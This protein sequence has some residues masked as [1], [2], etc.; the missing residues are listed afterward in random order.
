[1]IDYVKTICDCGGEVY[2]VGGAIRNHLYNNFHKTSIKTK[3][4]DLLVRLIDQENLVNILKKIGNVKEVGQAFGIII[5]VPFGSKEN[6]EIAIPRTE[7][8]TGS[9]YRDF[10]VTVDP[11]ISIKEDFSRRDATIN[12]IAMRIYSLDD[13]CILQ[14]TD[15]VIDKSNFI[16]PFYGIDDV[17]NKIWKCVGDPKKR[18]IEDPNRIMRAFR[19][20]AELGL[21]IEKSTLDAI[22]EDYEIMQTLIPQSYVRLYNEFF[23]MLETDNF[24]P[25]LK[26]MHDLGILEFLGMTNVNLKINNDLDLT[27]KIATL[28]QADTMESDIKCWCHEKQITATNYISSRDMNLLIAIQKFC[29]EV[30]SSDSKYSLL[31]IME[32]IYKLFK[33]ECYDIVKNIVCY[34]F[35]NNKISEIDQAKI[36]EHLE[37]TKLY[38]ASID[39]LVIN[40]NMLM[41]KWNIRGQ[42]IKLAK[43]FMLDSIFKDN[44]VNTVESLELVI[45]AF[46]FNV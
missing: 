34:M 45:D 8:S 22:S 44:C 11:N 6:T 24:L 18:F 43:D 14:N 3:D 30:A 41:S 31:K 28:I 26:I 17:Q 46:V 21:V 5:Y 9:G 4:Y 12:A 23:R 7:V 16:D 29:F 42:Q 32:K 25:N 19:Q 40:G 33:F 35:T 39:H 13:I 37:E 10:I 20:S 2:I 38:P 36:L 27:L 15:I 1:M